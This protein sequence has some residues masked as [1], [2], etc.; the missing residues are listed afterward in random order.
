MDVIV[1]QIHDMIRRRQL[2]Q[3]ELL[4]RQQIDRFPDKSN[5]WFL[6]GQILQM[7]CDFEGMLS[8]A[9]KVVVL[10]PKNISGYLQ[11]ID[12]L[13][14]G[15]KVDQ[16]IEKLDILK[17]KAGNDIKLLLH[18]AEFYTHAGQFQEALSCYQ[19]AHGLR[20]DDPR[21]LYNC[22]TANIALGQFNE[23]EKL[24]DQV[25]ALNPYDYDAYYNR[26][27]LRKQTP[28]NN[29]LDQLQDILE[30]S[31]ENPAGAAQV[32]YALAKENEDLGA[33]EKSFSYLKKGA[34]CRNSLLQYK[35]TDDEE[36]IDAIKQT[37][38]GD[39]FETV[40]PVDHRPGPVFII[41]LP[42]SGTTLVDRILCSHSDVES[43]GEINDF[44][45]SLMGTIGPTTGKL[46]LIQKSKDMDFNILGEKYLSSIKARSS[47]AP[48]LIDKTPA[49]Y[50]YL[51]LIARALPTAKI[52]HLRRNPMDSCYAIYKTLFRMG[53]P[54]SYNLENL[55]RYYIAYH[56]L[57]D[58]WR[59]YLPGR[60]LD[61]DYEELVQSQEKTSREIITYC[62]LTWQQNCLDFHLNNSPTAT[63][64]AAQVRQPIYKGSVEKWRL[65]E[66][67]LQ[68]LK[69]MLEAANIQFD[70]M[71]SK[72]NL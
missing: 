37:M 4:C 68:P 1:S 45:M 56:D 14:H 44:A 50:L 36:A 27:T 58:H 11:E 7:R 66:N 71:T 52:I 12:A 35:V 3:A 42:R 26:A 31:L 40:I 21:I 57:M 8:C 22:A 46:D 70:P 43:L 16:A 19:Q 39:F 2:S 17:N 5:L 24:L 64:S 33:H 15:G 32:Y 23:A 61:V 13:I 29:H 54:F 10:N 55:A 48:F 65:Y 6:L 69:K 63:A 67:E 49:N 60:F 51:G 41:G 9:L 28:E 53:Y 18:L 30:K 59:R 62:G 72:G 47:N 20:D 25:L 38:S 34:D